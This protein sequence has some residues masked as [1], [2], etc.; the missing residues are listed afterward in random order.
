MLSR[1]SAYD[2]LG[3]IALAPTG[4]VLGGFLYESIGANTTLNIAALTVIV[5]TVLVLCVKDVW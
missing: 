2:H 1:V 3:S 5:P 4:I